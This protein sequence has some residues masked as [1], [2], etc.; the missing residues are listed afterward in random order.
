MNTPESNVRPPLS[1]TELNALPE[2][3]Q[4]YVRF[5]EATIVQQQAQIQQFQEQVKEL[6]DRLSKTSSNSNKPPSSDGMKKKTKSQREKSERKPG[7]QYGRTGKGL[8]QVSDPD[9]VVTHSPNRCYGCGKQLDDVGGVCVEKRQVFEIPK[10]KVE[11]TEHRLEEKI[12]P[13]CRCR[14]KGGFPKGVNGPVQYGERVQALVAYF[15]HEHFVPVDRVCEILDDLFGIAL[16]PGTCSNIDEKLFQNLESFETALKAGLLASSILHFDETGMRCEKKLHWVHVASSQMATLYTI[17]PKRGQ[18]AMD[19][20][21]ILPNFHGTAVHDHWKPYFSYT[22]M[23][24]SL[25]N[26]HHLRELTFISEEKKEEWAYHMKELLIAAKLEVEKYSETGILP[27]EDLPKLEQR[28]QKIIEEGLSYHANLSPLPQ[29]SK[30]RQKQREGKNLLDRLLE[31]RECV[32]RF[33]HDFRVPF[34]NNQGERDIRMA[35]LKQ[36]ISGCF[37]SF[38]GGEI[39][40]RVRSYISTGR[41]QGWNIWQALSNAIRGS[42]WEPKPQETFT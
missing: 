12:C 10:P 29:S 9:V 28:Y 26:S 36:K 24:H 30:G 39:F 14:I 34:S 13:H 4:V 25:C 17:D 11:V 35:K 8:M 40:C 21:G 41:K 23:N 31:K 16:S 6:E 42:P 7:G 18:E 19:I 15:A 2:F 1:T 37:R 27:P 22:K 20:A 3:I 32:L 38:H 33:L 5:L